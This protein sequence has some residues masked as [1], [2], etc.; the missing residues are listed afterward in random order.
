[1]K[2]YNGDTFEVRGF[3][4]RVNFKDD[5]A[6]D[7]PWDAAGHVPAEWDGIEL[8]QYPADRA[9]DQFPIRKMERTRMKEYR[10]TVIVN[11]L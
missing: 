4:F 7:A 2:V 1:M 9:A 8:R 6:S 5:D 10:N 3:T 11:N